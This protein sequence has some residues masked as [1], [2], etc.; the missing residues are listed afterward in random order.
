MLWFMTYLKQVTAPLPFIYSILQPKD[1][2]WGIVAPVD[3]GNWFASTGFLL[4][5][6]LFV[7][8][9]WALLRRVDIRSAGRIHLCNRVNVA[10]FFSLGLVLL[11]PFIIAMVGRYQNAFGFGNGYL[12]VY[13]QSFGL[14]FFMA[15]LLHW[16]F[17]RIDSPSLR[18]AAS[19]V[20]GI[21]ISGNHANNLSVAKALDAAWSPQYVWAELL[22]NPSFRELCVGRPLVVQQPAPWTDWTMMRNV[23]RAGFKGVEPGK[24]ADLLTNTE[25]A[26][27]YCVA[28]PLL[29]MGRYGYVFN[30]FRNGKEISTPISKEISFIYPIDEGEELNDIRLNLG[31]DSEEFSMRR[32]YHQL[33]R[34]TDYAIFRVIADAGLMR[35]T[36]AGIS[37]HCVRD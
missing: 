21:L 35:H 31:C 13:F 6:P 25:G 29:W 2:N 12:P 30:A 27:E 1:G 22:H 9:N 11:P 20:I 8:V 19:V 5:L 28:S 37:S 17:L 15:Y 3:Y 4:S 33:G 18:L 32:V 7:F 16:L 24:M 34:W 14:S 10:L 36:S 26:V 23:T